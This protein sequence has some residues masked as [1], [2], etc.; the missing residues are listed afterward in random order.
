MTEKRDADAGTPEWVER[1]DDTA[2]SSEAQPEL[3]ERGESGETTDSERAAEDEWYATADAQSVH[4]G[5]GA[6]IGS[7]DWSDEPAFE[8]AAAHEV[9]SAAADRNAAVIAAEAD[10]LAAERAARKE[11]RV[12]AL[13][14]LTEAP[15]PAERATPALVSDQ[16]VAPAV[17]VKR[18]TDGFLGSLG[19]FLLRLV[20]AGIVG[21]SGVNKLLD[22]T[23]AA[24]VYAN[25][26]L[27]QPA[28]VALGVGVVEVAIALALVFGLLTR[29]A[30]LGLALVAGGTLALVLWGP[31]SPF[32]P[33]AARFVGDFELL[34]AAIG[35]LFLC[36]GGGGW[37]VDGGLRRRREADR[38]ASD[39]A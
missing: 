25:T 20:T 15:V 7:N 38:R 6:T 22:P 1:Q 23:R 36:V 12:A 29:V 2:V 14:P 3:A 17:V 18:S 11:A 24:D 4:A 5:G 34:L 16:G 21:L 27:P 30:G 33:G 26:I 10:R 32:Q 19:L 37:A 39:V 9:D 13:T 28:L 8:R 31:W 35:V